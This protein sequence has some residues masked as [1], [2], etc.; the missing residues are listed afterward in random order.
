MGP[1]ARTGKY[2][3]PTTIRIDADEQAGEQRRAGRE[4]PGR[5]RGLLLA[6]ERARDGERGM[7]RK[8]R[9]T[10]IARPSAVL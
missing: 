7:I 2:V 6:S 3:R 5:R 10:S 8:N 9:P 4:G 1:S